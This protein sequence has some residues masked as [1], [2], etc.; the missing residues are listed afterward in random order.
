MSGKDDIISVYSD[1]NPEEWEAIKK[2]MGK[3]TRKKLSSMR[4]VIFDY[5]TKGLGITQK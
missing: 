4:K 3:R 5:Y 2:E 1:H